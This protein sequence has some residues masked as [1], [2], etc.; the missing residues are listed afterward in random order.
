[1]LEGRWDLK[2]GGE[3]FDNLDETKHVIKPRLLSGYWKHFYAPGWGYKTPYAILKIAVDKDGRVK[4]SSQNALE[5]FFPKIKEA[6]HMSRQAFSL[7]RQKV[8]FRGTGIFA[9]VFVRI[10]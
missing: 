5:R 2:G 8:R 10:R 3:F 6:A 1:M 4:E 7:A 9:L